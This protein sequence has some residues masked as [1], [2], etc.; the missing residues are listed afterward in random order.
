VRQSRVREAVRNKGRRS[1]FTQKAGGGR[2]TFVDARTRSELAKARLAELPAQRSRAAS[3]SRRCT[4]WTCGS[5]FV[6]RCCPQHG[7]DHPIAQKPLIYLG[8][9][10]T[11]NKIRKGILGVASFIVGSYQRRQIDPFA[12]IGRPDPK[13]DPV[14]V[15]PK[16]IF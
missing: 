6:S 2:S 16:T 15:N 3:T 8:K 1:T 9:P 14:L 12:M 11:I 10:C 5:L 4:A 13:E 7:D